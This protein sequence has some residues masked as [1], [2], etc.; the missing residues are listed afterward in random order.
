MSSQSL[1]VTHVSLKCRF[2]TSQLT[3]NDAAAFEKV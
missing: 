1:S 3:P 2:G